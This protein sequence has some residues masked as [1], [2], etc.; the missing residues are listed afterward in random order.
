M[1]MRNLFALIFLWQCSIVFS[2]HVHNENCIESPAQLES[3]QPSSV[4]CLSLYK[5]KL[6]SFPSQILLLENLEFLDLSKNK[7]DYVPQEISKLKSLKEINLSKNKM[8]QFPVGIC[9]IENLESLSLSSNPLTSLPDCFKYLSNLKKLDL[10]ACLFGS[11]PAV[12]AQMGFIENLDMQGMN[13]SKKEQE[14]WRK[15]ILME[16]EILFDPPCNCLG[17]N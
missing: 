1:K 10:F 3:A 14:R 8:T 15:E 12:L 4:T 5:K 17:T 9:S 13:F 6:K 11:V 7:I 16:T 2:Q